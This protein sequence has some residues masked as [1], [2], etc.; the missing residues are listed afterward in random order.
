MTGR[1]GRPRLN[2]PKIMQDKPV[3]IPD[4]IA[5]PI[6]GT[7]GSVY[8]PTKEIKPCAVQLL[9]GSTWAASDI[10]SIKIMPS[11]SRYIVQVFVRP[12]NHWESYTR[13][14]ERTQADESA[15]ILRSELFPSVIEGVSHNT[16]PSNSKL[17]IP[18]AQPIHERT[19]D[20][21][22]DDL[23]AL[24][25]GHEDDEPIYDLVDAE[26]RRKAGEPGQDMNRMILAPDEY[27]RTSTDMT[28]QRVNEDGTLY[29][30]VP[31]TKVPPLLDM[32]SPEYLAWWNEQENIYGAQ[33]AS[34]NGDATVPAYVQ[35]EDFA[36]AIED[37]END[38]A[39]LQEEQVL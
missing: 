32:T 1:P 21:D 19:R 26:N 39:E 16:P 18:P 31:S 8:E 34:Q 3:I 35:G 14:H 4:F 22:E 10:A 29:S 30:P 28:R 11:D 37:S 20:Q 7:Q 13:H 23:S 38:R 9:D 15:S 25:R 24:M 5:S 33:I 6:E 2:Q 36:R 12:L 17:G 27:G